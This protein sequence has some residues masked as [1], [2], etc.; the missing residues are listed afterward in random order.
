MTTSNDPQAAAAPSKPTSRTRWV[1]TLI[2]VLVAWAI[3]AYLLVPWLW[4]EHFRHDAAADAIPNITLT[5]DGHPGDP[6]NISIVGDDRQL[7]LAM[8]AAG[9]VPA[10]PITFDTSVRIAV[11]S[12][13]R[14]PDNDAPV[15]ALFLY[16]RKQD[17]AF[18]QPIGHSP[19]QRHHVRFWRSS[20]TDDSQPG[21]PRW[22]GSATLDERVGLS[23]TTGQVTHHIGPDVDAERDRIV[24]ELTDAG[25]VEKIEWI[26]GF[27][28]QLEGRN[29]G[30]DLWRTDGRLAIVTLRGQA[31][32]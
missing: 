1:R 28:T 27:H 2:I 31:V 29:G 23:H 5:G 4:K 9:W 20:E 32:R 7:V 3:A 15:S 8:G 30:G 16:K 22:I 11:D 10:D 13:I 18:E 14:R 25:W 26:D 17:L 19:A 6:L 21:A 12:V 24:Q